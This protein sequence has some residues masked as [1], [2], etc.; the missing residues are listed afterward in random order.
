MKT[1]RNHSESRR[2]D[3][4]PQTKIYPEC[5]QPFKEKYHKQRWIVKGKRTEKEDLVQI[6]DSLERSLLT[7]SSELLSKLLQLLSILTTYQASFAC[8]ISL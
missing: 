6:L 2:I 8:D 4:Y 5:C 1:A 3:L 7:H